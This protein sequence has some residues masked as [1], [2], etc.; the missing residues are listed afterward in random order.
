MKTLPKVRLWSGF[1]LSSLCLAAAPG[2][3][4]NEW[5]NPGA[6]YWNEPSNWDLG[7]PNNAGGWAIGSITNGGT[8]IVTNT[9]PNV[10]E[11]WAG[12][13]GAA[14]KII[15]TNGGT[16]PVDNWLV[17]GRTGAGG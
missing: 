12:N 6:G 17:V 14:G 15:V 11:A 2:L 3:R 4:A 8:A 9:V 1:L 5:V 13:A 10:S 16:L 7:V